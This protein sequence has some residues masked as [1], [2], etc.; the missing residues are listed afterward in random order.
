MTAG[1]TV[2]IDPGHL[3]GGA[4]RC[5]AAVRAGPC[6]ATSLPGAAS[7]VVDIEDGGQLTYEVS[8]QVPPGSLDTVTIAATIAPAVS[9]SDPELR[10]NTQSIRL[11][12]DR[13]FADSFE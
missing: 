3:L 9:A 1:A 2:S 11:R 6:P 13:L 10:N 12:L 7:A 5:V 4:W 8:G